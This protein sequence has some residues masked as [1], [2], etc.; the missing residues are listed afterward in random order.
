M[1]IVNGFQ[2]LT[3]ITKRS[4]LDVTAALDPPLHISQNLNSTRLLLLT[5]KIKAHNAFVF[6]ITVSPVPS[7]TQE[8]GPSI[9]YLINE[10]FKAGFIAPF[11]IQVDFVRLRLHLKFFA[12]LESGNI[13]A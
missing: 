11:K 3:I 9:V 4:I 1:I 7:F 2:P 5:S 10:D 12:I 8:K 6:L 13:L